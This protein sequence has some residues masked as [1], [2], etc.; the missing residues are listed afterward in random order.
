MKL[1]LFWKSL[2]LTLLPGAV[3][4][5]LL[6]LVFDAYLG[7]R[8][9]VDIPV[10][11]LLEGLG[12][13]SAIVIA[14]LVLILR[15]N[16]GLPPEF[17]WIAT[18]LIGMGLLDGV[19]AVVLPGESF[20]WLHSLATLFGGLL[21]SMVIFASSIKSWPLIQR[22]PSF[23]AL[24]ILFIGIASIFFPESIPLM[25]YRAGFTPLAEALNILG[26]IG[27]ITAWIHF[28]F[29]GDCLTEG[30]RL[31]LAN[32]ALLFGVAALLFHFSHL[33]DA[34]WWL[35]HILRLIA[36][37]ILLR[38]F[39]SRYEV[40]SKQLR[41]SKSVIAHTKEA[42][43][44]T[45]EE[46]VI[47][48]VNPAYERMTGFTSAEL[49]DRLFAPLQGNHPMQEAY[50]ELHSTMLEHGHWTG[51]VWE[52]KKDGHRYPQRLTIDAVLDSEGRTSN[53]VAIISDITQQKKL[54]KD[55]QQLAFYD[56]LTLLPNRS[57]F[58][59]QLEGTLSSLARRKRKGALLMIDLDGFK[60]VNDSQG[61]AAGDELLRLFAQ[62]LN[63]RIR[64]SD[65]AARI[66]G[67]EFCILMHEI[68]S[69]E[70]PSILA[71]QLLNALSE[72]V[73]LEGIQHSISASIGIAIYPDHA[74]TEDGLLRCSDSALYQA[75]TAGKNN[76]KVYLQDH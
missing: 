45:D 50:K 60:Q 72:P 48:H 55:L 11:S 25:S 49:I 14:L 5:V 7:S 31:V 28:I 15:H 44:I 71:R 59:Q 3:I 17:L 2:Y 62:R 64:R 56:P 18:A 47:C 43:L 10:H 13:F 37:L 4:S 24:L 21:F 70:E 65:T 33:W 22:A 46:G 76:F 61:H 54:E 51:E 69:V 52:Q 63:Q 16:R 9:W 8:F 19:H 6:M 41:L 66:G 26:G 38:F 34:T 68:I 42:V 67:D 57:L 30:E 75:K 35:W 40:D 23:I 36:Y 58:S 32:H 1:D 12:S 39:I 53:Y 27:F 74:D 73:E 29:R 20:I